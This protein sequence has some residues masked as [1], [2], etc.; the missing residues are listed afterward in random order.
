MQ[1]ARSAGGVAAH[2]E[3]RHRGRRERNPATALAVH[4]GRIT[5]NPTL[6]VHPFTIGSALDAPLALYSTP[7]QESPEYSAAN[8]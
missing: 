3:A 7:D 5:F 2:R 8:G 4:I 1:P 6:T